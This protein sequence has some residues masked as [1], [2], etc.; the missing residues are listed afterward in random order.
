M[1]K[2][3]ME[4][5]ELSDLRLAAYIAEFT[6]E[7]SVEGDFLVTLLEELNCR[8]EAAIEEHRHRL[9]QEPPR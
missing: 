1:T 2:S 7:E 8:L 6:D 9:E 5:R 3:V 4:I